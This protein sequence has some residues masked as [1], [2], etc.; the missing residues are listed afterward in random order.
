MGHESIV[1]LLVELVIGPASQLNDLVTTLHGH[2]AERAFTS[3]LTTDP[4][5]DG[6]TKLVLGT[7]QEGGRGRRRVVLITLSD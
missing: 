4:G 6:L 3:F 2:V 5:Q 7:L 1:A